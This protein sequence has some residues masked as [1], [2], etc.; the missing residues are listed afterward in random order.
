M[1]RA[2]LKTVAWIGILILASLR[3]VSAADPLAPDFQIREFR[4]D[5]G[6]HKYA[7]Y[8]PPNYKPDQKWPVVLFLHGAGERGTDGLLPTQVGLGAVIRQQKRPFPAIVVFPQI[9]PGGR[10][11]TAWSPDRVGGKRALAILQQVE[12]DYSI[13][14]HRRVLTGWSMG[15]FGAWAIGAAH[16]DMWSAVLPLSG[17]GDPSKVA[18]LKN[19]R[20]WAL[21][22]IDDT[23]V[24]VKRSEQ[25]ASA[26]REAGGDPTYQEL[27][28]GHD[29]WRYAYA[30]PAVQ[31][32]MLA[33]TG[34][35]PQD[36]RWQEILEQQRRRAPAAPFIPAIVVPRSIGVRLGNDALMSI[37]RGLP[38]VIPADML[39]GNVAPIEKTFDVAGDQYKVVFSDLTFQAKLVDASLQT[40][41]TGRLEI[42]FQLDH[43]T[44]HVGRITLRSSKQQAQAGPIDVVMGHCR[45]IP[46]RVEIRP[47]IE[48][49][50]LRLVV[51]NSE[52]QV[53]DNNWYVSP[54]QNLKST[55]QGLNEHELTSGLTG[56]IYLQKDRIESQIRSLVPGLMRRIED[57]M[58]VDVPDR[59][60]SMLWP[61]PVQTPRIRIQPVEIWIDDDGLSV[62]ADAKIGSSR[63]RSRPIQTLSDGGVRVNSLGHGRD[64][65]LIASPGLVEGASVI[66]IEEGNAEINVLDLPEATFHRLAERDVWPGLEPA[67]GDRELDVNL[68]VISPM[69]LAAAR[70][71]DDGLTIHLN[72]P[73]ARLVPVD[74]QG[75]KLTAREVPF[76]LSQAIRVDLLRPGHDQRQTA[77]EWNSQP[78]LT[79]L[80]QAPG[81]ERVTDLFRDAWTAWARR[82][83]H[84]TNTKDLQVGDSR[85][86]IDQIVAPQ[87]LIGAQFD[88]P[89]IRLRNEGPRTFSYRVRSRGSYWTEWLEVRP[90]QSH[91]YASSPTLEWESPSGQRGRFL[92]GGDIAV[93]ST[94][95]VQ[96][97]VS[98]G[99]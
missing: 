59:L 42:A 39:Q 11:L 92:P 58:S 46:L 51:E 23:I 40:T 20:V 95:P 54:L 38:Q 74:S 73:R 61:L 93:D 72:A 79:C 5:A 70:Q 2:P 32:W 63:P 9:E 85:L 94:G 33:A 65:E 26:L 83:T 60:A 10:I 53:S 80:S 71:G 18:A 36:V 17:G 15:G 1:P 12:S 87:E 62:V 3:T 99:R 97:E 7:I 89:A 22:G 50:K 37:A 55:G 31:D 44:L 29:C 48:K 8:V 43:L 6:I 96:V 69:T 14:P 76:S 30:H 86:R 77:I 56:G 45:P 75:R 19:S 13:D 91:D 66:Q 35:P 28:V 78:D 47:M 98:D 34:A 41:N 16:P 57:Q 90:G 88:V 67:P 68:E 81:A 84:T 52:F 4:D 49:G 64:L 27:P 25:M 24:D 21:H 82:Q